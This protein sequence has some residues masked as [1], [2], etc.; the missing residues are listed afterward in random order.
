MS[1][2]SSC[3]PPALC[4]ALFLAGCAVP[5][6]APQSTPAPVAATPARLV[7]VAPGALD[8]TYQGQRV[9][10]MAG[11]ECGLPG[12]IGFDVSGSTIRLRTHKLRRALGG[13]VD[14]AGRFS[15]TST[16]GTRTM[17]GSIDGGRLTAEETTP[18]HHRRHDAGEPVPGGVCTA[19]VTATRVTTPPSDDGAGGD[20]A[21]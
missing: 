12:A 3:L 13:P 19:R 2:L 1:R 8:G 10:D 9:P 11:P 6:T 4:S 7:A 20:E 17:A 14:G 18:P 21:P 16:D 5:A 15:M